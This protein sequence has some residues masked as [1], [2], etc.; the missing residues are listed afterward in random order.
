VRS[1]SDIRVAPG[2]RPRLASTPTDSKLGIGGREE[3]AARAADLARRLRDLQSLLVSARTHALVVVLQGMDG[4]GKDG[5]ARAL[6]RELNPM[7]VRAVGFRAPDETE[8][9]H[10]FLWRIH[11]VFPPRGEIA[12]LNRSHYEDVVTVPV[13]GIAPEEVWR[14]RFGAIREFERRMHEEGT[15]V[16]KFLL[17]IS[18]DEQLERLR[19]RATEPLKRWKH[20]GDDYARR[21]RWDGYM[22]AYEM[23]IAE[24]S[25]PE[26]PWF[27]VP[28]DRKWVRD[29][30]VLQ[31]VVDRLEALDLPEPPMPEDVPPGLLDATR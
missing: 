16:L 28:A 15:V 29:V 20:S 19:E 5:T 9:R 4:S 24:T 13:E 26:S 27:V 23:A 17:H 18:R 21:A 2:T 12:I 8:R 11:R 7:I 30:A 25:T 1:I 31:T 10:D 3:A 22:A 14:P 6:T